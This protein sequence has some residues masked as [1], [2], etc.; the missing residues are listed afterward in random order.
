MLDGRQLVDVALVLAEYSPKATGIQPVE[1]ALTYLASAV[2]IW[3]VSLNF[4]P[5]ASLHDRRPSRRR[6]DTLVHSRGAAH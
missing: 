5:V 2:P 3:V 4:G 1:D 6:A